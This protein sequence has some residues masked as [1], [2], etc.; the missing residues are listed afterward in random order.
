MIQNMTS[1][2]TKLKARLDVI[3]APGYSIEVRR[4]IN[5]KKDQIKRLEEE[6]RKLTHEKFQREKQINRVISAGQPDAMHEIQTKV[7][8]MTIVFDKLEKIN[9]QLS[10]QE[11]TK[12][13]AERQF[14]ETKQ[15][16][17][18]LEQRAECKQLE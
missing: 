13:E 17:Q 14:E 16:L 7:Q 6:R 12:Q 18:E 1:E 3:G 4:Q 10:F 5:E 2:Y 9:K 15:K 11:S 8:E